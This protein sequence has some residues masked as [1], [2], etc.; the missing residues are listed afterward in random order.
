M[1]WW[2][3]L[4]EPFDCIEELDDVDEVDDDED[5]EDEPFLMRDEWFLDVVLLLLL[6][7]KLM[8]VEMDWHCV[9]A[10]GGGSGGNG[11]GGWGDDADEDDDDEWSSK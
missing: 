6:I 10:G 1:V 5:D 11:G 7:G 8:G 4:R 3:P 2:D 9:R